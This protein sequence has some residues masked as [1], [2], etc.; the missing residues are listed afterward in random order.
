MLSDFDPAKYSIDGQKE[1]QDVQTLLEDRI[2]HFAGER[3]LIMSAHHMRVAADALG[4]LMFLEY[5]D[6]ACWNIKSF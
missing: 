3:G 2:S 6:N 5:P 4:F 1:W